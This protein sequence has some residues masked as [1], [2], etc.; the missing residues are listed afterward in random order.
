MIL[1]LHVEMQLLLQSALA[2]E[3]GPLD[4]ATVVLRQQAEASRSASA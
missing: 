4:T 3:L 2:L 1:K